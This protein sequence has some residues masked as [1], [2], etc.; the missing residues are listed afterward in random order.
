MSTCPSLGCAVSAD[1]NLLD[2]SQIKWYNDA[3]DEMPL[4]TPALVMT[5]KAPIHPLFQSSSIP[6]IKVAGSRRSNRATRPSAR[7]IDPD[8]A[9]ALASTTGKRVR[10]ND[11]ELKE[12]QLAFAPIEGCHNAIN[13]SKILVRIIDKYGLRKKVRELA[14]CDDPTHFELLDGVV[15]SRWSSC[16]WYMP[17]KGWG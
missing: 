10:K 3:D 15:Y 9:E 1:G 11:W 13:Q 12:E 7:A 8:N 6:G 17:S 5:E 4:P 2:A 14:L 16:E